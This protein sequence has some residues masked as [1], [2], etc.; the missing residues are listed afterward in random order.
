MVKILAIHAHPDDLEIL[1]AGT[2]ALL[3]AAGHG[4]VMATLTAGDCGS[5]GPGPE[6]T[7]AIRRG[8]AA[9]AAAMIGAE[10]ACLGFPDLAVFNDDP[11]RRRVTELLRSVAPALVITAPPADYHPDHEATSALVRDAC[12]AASARNYRTGPAA[13][14]AA[15]PHLYFTDPIGGRDREGRKI[16]PDFAVD[17]GPRFETKRAM[18]AAH[19]SQVA[20]LADQHN[21][22]DP[23]AAMEAWTRRRG[24][25]FGVAHAEAFRH[26]RGEPYPR[27]PLLQD[28]VGRALLVKRQT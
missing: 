26:Y 23:L 20:W 27:T 13:P 6:E 19:L 28:L 14:L 9:A 2:L 1:A 21:L 10:Y 24:A 11:T 12:F 7:A 5:S 17:I 8:E 25:E 3:A 15:V 22:A 18:L 4:I 16:A